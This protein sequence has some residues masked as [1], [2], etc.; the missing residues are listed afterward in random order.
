LIVAFV[1]FCKGICYAFIEHEHRKLLHRAT[2]MIFFT[3]QLYEGM[4]P[5]SGWERRALREWLRRSELFRRYIAVIA[6]LLPSPVV[7]LCNKTLH[8]AVIESVEQSKGS[9]TFLMD[10]RR[11]LGGFAGRRIRLSFAGVRR[12]IRIRGLVGHWWLYEEA[13]LC[14]RA[15]FA[16]HVMFD[17]TE[18]E[19]EADE[20]RIQ[21]G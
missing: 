21:K 1:P 2:R 12:P 18:I 13:H 9:L 17:N 14:S 20:L 4:Q 5:K 10:A 7:R 8:D 15:K 3:R 11:A 16:L 6:P 19:I